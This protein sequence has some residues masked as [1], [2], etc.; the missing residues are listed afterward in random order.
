[1]NSP[2]KIGISPRLK[3]R[4]V[5][6]AKNISIGSVI[7]RC[8]VIIYPNQQ[9]KLVEKTIFDD[10]VYVWNS[11]F[12]CFVL[13]FGSLYNHSYT[14]N[15]SYRRDYKNQQMLYITLRD[16]KKGDEL[17]M[18]YNGDPES[19]EPVDKGHISFDQKLKKYINQ[20]SK[21]NSLK[22]KLD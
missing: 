20:S 6:A 9:E 21:F 22:E 1:M 16:I 11:K 4:G 18:N 7:E 15:I 3:I 10:Y 14:P 2:I 17:L 8:P 12:D 5:I 13:G 19:Q